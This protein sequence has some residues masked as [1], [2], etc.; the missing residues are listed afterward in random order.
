MIRCY[1]GF[2]REMLKCMVLCTK[3]ST[4]DSFTLTCLVCSSDGTIPAPS[5]PIPISVTV[6]RPL[7]KGGLFKVC[8]SFWFFF[9]FFFSFS[10]KN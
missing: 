10:M 4:H 1:V 5:I 6:F 7:P 9:F 2:W 3:T 8:T